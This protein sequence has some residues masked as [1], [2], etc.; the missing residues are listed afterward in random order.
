M[1]ICPECSEKIEKCDF[2]GAE[3]EDGYLVVCA[4]DSEHHF[5]SFDC[6]K[7]WLLKEWEEEHTVAENYVEDE[8]KEG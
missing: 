2:C 6:L 8:D 4:G 1:L 3:F 5:C 7:E